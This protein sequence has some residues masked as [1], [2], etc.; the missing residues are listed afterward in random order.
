[1]TPAMAP[2]APMSGIEL[3]GNLATWVARAANPDRK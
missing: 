2:E 1:M 3:C